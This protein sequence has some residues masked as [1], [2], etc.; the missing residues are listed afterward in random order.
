LAERIFDYFKNKR[1]SY[2]H[3]LA[4]IRAD[5]A[6]F[7][8][9]RIG[10]YVGFADIFMDNKPNA[11]ELYRKL[12]EARALEAIRKNCFSAED[13]D[14]MLKNLHL[15]K[16]MPYGIVTNLARVQ[17]TPIPRKDTIP[18][19]MNI[20]FSDNV[21]KFLILLTKIV[22]RSEKHE[23]GAE[24]RFL[25]N[26]Y[27]AFVERRKS[28]LAAIELHKLLNGASLNIVQIDGKYYV[29]GNDGKTIKGMEIIM[30]RQKRTATGEDKEIM[31]INVRLAKV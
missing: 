13:F 20:N 4:H 11:T 30:F 7:S 9:E 23:L 19:G 26:K 1:H 31:T 6:R 16:A 27:K 22:L 24:L 18:P 14:T 10:L 25:D 29:L 12:V 17:S 8:L 3:A 28:K 21:F 15:I 5:A 2:D